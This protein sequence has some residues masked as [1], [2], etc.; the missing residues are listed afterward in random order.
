MLEQDF[1]IKILDA[2]ILS[3]AYLTAD[4]RTQLIVSAVLTKKT[5]NVAFMFTYA[6]VDRFNEIYATKDASKTAG[7]TFMLGNADSA[8]WLFL[9]AMQLFDNIPHGKEAYRTVLALM[10][11][12]LSFAEMKDVLVKAGADGE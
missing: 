6:D 11:K 7:F 12:R 10:L 4:A 9:N 8:K 5:D 2:D 1:D 3:T